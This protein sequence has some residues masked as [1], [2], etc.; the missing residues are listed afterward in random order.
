MTKQPT[1]IELATSL[2]QCLLAYKVQLKSVSESLQSE[3]DKRFK[4]EVKDYPQKYFI[5]VSEEY[6]NP[7]FY[8]SEQSKSPAM[9]RC[10]V[11]KQTHKFDTLGEL[12]TTVTTMIT[13]YDTLKQAQYDHEQDEA[14]RHARLIAENST[15]GSPF[16][17]NRPD[18]WLDST[19]NPCTLGKGQP[20]PHP[21]TE[22][23]D[24]FPNI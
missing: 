14:Y 23:I 20:F 24:G 12:V 6:D 13:A 4:S 22:P 15:Y 8:L 16:G 11:Y 19:G 5:V 3:L 18:D 1:K 10:G 7:I 21:P 17:G 2:D 9:A